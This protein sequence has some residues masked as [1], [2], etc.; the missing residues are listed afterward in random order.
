MEA[1]NEYS[2]YHWMA[3]EYVGQDLSWQ[4]EPG[5]VLAYDR[6]GVNRREGEAPAEPLAEPLCGSA[7]A[8]PSR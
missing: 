3:N 6:L 4:Q 7:G 5:Q 8:S 1:A 2:I